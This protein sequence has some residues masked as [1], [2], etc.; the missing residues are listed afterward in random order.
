MEIK[1]AKE[2]SHKHVWEYYSTRRMS[3]GQK[4]HTYRCGHVD[5]KGKPDCLD[6]IN[7]KRIKEVNING[8]EK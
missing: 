8:K 1:E 5:M 7:R 2:V 3:T 4:V 6:R